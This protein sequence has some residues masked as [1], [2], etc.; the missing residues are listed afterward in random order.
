MRYVIVGM[1]GL[2]AMMANITQAQ[3]SNV[4]NMPTGQTSLQ[5]VS[6]GD[7]G[8]VSDTTGYGAV[9]Y[10]YQIGKYDVTNAQY[11]E[12]L[13][14]KA[15][16]SDPYGL[17]NNGMSMFPSS[18]IN[19]SG[20]GPY[21]YSVKPGQGNQPVECVTWFDTVRFANW[22]TNG[23]GNGNTETGSYT[24]LGGTPTPSNWATIKRN[25]GAQW[26]LPTEN[27]WYKAAYYKGGGT[28]VGY[29][30][31]ATQ[32]NTAPTWV[33][34]TAAGPNGGKNSA[35]FYD[36]TNGY[37][38]TGSTDW[39][40]NMDYL[41]DVGAYPDSLSAYGTLDQCGNVY[42][43]NEGD[44]FG[45][46]SYRC[47]RGGSFGSYNSLFLSASSRAGIQPSGS[48]VGLGFRVASV[49]EPGSLAMLAGIAATALL[50]W[51]RRRGQE[52]LVY[53]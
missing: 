31:Y 42:Q 33:L 37:V 36:P 23:Q 47:Y 13:T 20:T 9:S 12:F 32:S 39:D 53:S 22:L 38:L 26:V 50:H 40:T 10:N 15:T 30:S 46:G 41:T 51:W 1:I 11:A 25:P 18:G 5:F 16:D 52:N 17:W 8:N 3:V 45:D 21:T 19:R 7:P 43:L 44:I 28:N 48:S 6:V 29:W 49:P 2:V 4:F 27:E 34:S 35:N 24:L 14:D